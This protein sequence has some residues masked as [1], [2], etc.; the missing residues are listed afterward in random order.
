MKVYAWLIDLN[1]RRRNC[2]TGMISGWVQKVTEHRGTKQFG[3]KHFPWKIQ[4]TRLMINNEIWA[5][6]KRK[7]QARLPSIRT[8]V[9]WAWSAII[10]A[11]SGPK[12]ASFSV[13]SGTFF[14][15]PVFFTGVGHRT[16][17][18]PT[19]TS[20]EEAPRLAA[21]DFVS[22]ATTSRYESSGNR[23]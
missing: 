10:F 14:P 19:V 2:P 9:T 18:C 3:E 20:V 1:H 6:T 22:P 21:A 4:S 17:F 15:R 8:A 12:S 5:K 16:D 23:A 7:F 11:W 13:R